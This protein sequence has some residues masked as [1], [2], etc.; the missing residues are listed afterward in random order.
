MDARRQIARKQRIAEF[1]QTS[2]CKK[3]VSVVELNVVCALQRPELYVRQHPIDGQSK[4]GPA[5][6]QA[7]ITGVGASAAEDCRGPPEHPFAWHHVSFRVDQ[8]VGWR[9]KVVDVLYRTLPRR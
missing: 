3:E 5:R 9:W 6:I 7:E 8:L 2:P 4:P 1:H